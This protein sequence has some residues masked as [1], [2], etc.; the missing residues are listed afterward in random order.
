MVLVGHSYGGAVISEAGT[1][2]KV[3]GLVYVA[4]FAPDA[5]ESAGSLLGSLPPILLTFELRPGAE[6]FLKMT[7]QG[8]L[9]AFAQELSEEEKTVLFA[10]HAPTHGRSLGGNVTD[11]TWKKTRSWYIVAANDRVIDPKLE[12]AFAQKMNATT[13]TVHTSHLAMLAAPKQVTDIIL[14]A[15]RA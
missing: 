2:P 13:I 9:E 4:A 12:A 6:G 14:S 1:D 10:T 11:P 3:T 8:Y 5:G 15:T 7:R